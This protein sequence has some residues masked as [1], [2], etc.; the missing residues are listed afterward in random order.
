[1]HTMY[2]YTHSSRD[3]FIN[4]ENAL[5]LWLSNDLSRCEGMSV[6]SERKFIKLIL[7]QIFLRDNQ[8]L[9]ISCVSL[10]KLKKPQNTL[11]TS[12]QNGIAMALGKVSP[13]LVTIMDMP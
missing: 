4:V 2:T 10:T 12:P 3:L 9:R 5:F 7:N 1:M 13:R 6:R 8:S 11:G